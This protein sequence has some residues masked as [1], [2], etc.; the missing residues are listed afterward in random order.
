M[1]RTKQTARKKVAGR[2]VTGVEA[3]RIA[4]AGRRISAARLELAR[5]QAA[6]DTADIELEALGED[7][8][9]A[10]IAALTD[11]QAIAHAAV[12][13]ARDEVAAAV[14]DA[15]LGVTA[16]RCIRCIRCSRCILLELTCST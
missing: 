8:T 11:A 6:A 13:A 16:A 2:L 9:L 7:A 10:E 5:A 14:R 4:E 12:Q 15:N 1:A 3:Q